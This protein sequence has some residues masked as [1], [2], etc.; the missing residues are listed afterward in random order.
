[1]SS[2]VIDTSASASA[3]DLKLYSVLREFNV[4]ELNRLSKFVNSSYFNKNERL[5][6]LFEQYESIIRNGAASTLTRGQ[7]WSSATL[8]TTYN[9]QKFRKLCSDLLRLIE[10]FLVQ[11]QF[12][13]NPLHK[14]DY[15]IQAINEKK[16]DALTTSSVRTARRLSDQYFFRPASYYYYQYA[17]ERGIYGMNELEIDRSKVMNV[18]QIAQ[19]LDTFYLAEKMRYYCYALVRQPLVDHEYDFLLMDEIISH[20]AKMGYDEIVPINFYY[21]IYLTQKEPEN[22]VH[23]TRLKSLIHDYIDQLPNIEAKEVMDAAF[24]FCIRQINNGN[25]LYVKELFE[26]YKESLRNELIYVNGI[27][28]PWNFRNI[29]VS[30]LRL[31][32]YTWIDRFIHD[33]QDRI[34]IK[35]R[36]NAV[37]FNK[38]N[39]Y[40]YQ[41]KYDQVM[42]LLQEVEY[43][44]PSYNLNSKAML[45]ATYYELDEVE[46]L[47]SLLSSFAVYLRR[48]KSIPQQ[49]KSHY[50]NLVR[51]VRM[52][53]RTPIGDKAAL[54]K[55][56]K[57]VT[58]VEG[59][60]NKS[61]LL[62]KIDE[63]L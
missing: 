43:E 36:S 42:Q 44:D 50:Q 55:L 7:A 22:T 16:L 21:Q 23:Y 48:G 45:I 3:L 63:L 49:R 33:Y 46:P 51:F 32:E 39:L 20:I 9:D 38:A 10:Q 17:F 40:F 59:M 25:K 60:V 53:V 61:W 41:K 29:I 14:A 47:L 56:R 31:G 8:D 19:N 34:D 57:K 4:Y 18:E 24:N 35:H 62:D 13:K 11:E 1:M 54:K 58:D 12:E 28:D 37:S 6:R 26:L 2:R 15:L 27:L 52:L 30:G 5:V